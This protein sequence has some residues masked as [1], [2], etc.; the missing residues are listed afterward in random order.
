[1]LRSLQ[2]RDQFKRVYVREACETFPR[3]RPLDTGYTKMQ[4]ANETSTSREKGVCDWDVGGERSCG[5]NYILGGSGLDQ[6]LLQLQRQRLP[7]FVA[8]LDHLFPP[9]PIPVIDPIENPNPRRVRDGLH[10]P[11]I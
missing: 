7:L 9:I 8:Q 1:M 2:F 3:T 5:D 10:F 6:C 4:R 11:P